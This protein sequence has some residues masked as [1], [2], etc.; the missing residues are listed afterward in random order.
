MGAEEEVDRRGRG[1]AVDGG[2][3]EGERRRDVE[4]VSKGWCGREE[5]ARRCVV[6]ARTRGH[7]RVQ[8]SPQAA[9]EPR[10][11][12]GSTFASSS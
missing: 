7:T 2:G 9:E 8:P 5:G 10:N 12:T 11:L 4:G 3:G 6:V 1:R